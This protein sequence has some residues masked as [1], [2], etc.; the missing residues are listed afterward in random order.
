MVREDHERVSLPKSLQAAANSQSI[1]LIDVDDFLARLW[2]IHLDVKAEGYVHEY[3][4]GMFRSDYMLDTSS[5]PTSLKQVEFNSIS[6]SF[7]GLASLVT[8]LHTELLSFPTP[9]QPLAYPAHPL[10]SSIDANE[11]SS[12]KSAGSPPTN[13]AVPTLIASLAAAHA[14]YGSSKHSPPLPLCVLF[15]V[16]D[17]ERN[18]FDQLALSSHLF[19]HHKIPS[20]RIPTSAIISQTTIPSTQ[21]IRA[22]DRI[23]GYNLRIIVID[24]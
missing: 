8:K 21:K 4:L 12:L 13:E 3:S 7:G 14:A 11:P 22:L 23:L 17:S 19:N 9:Q 20:F 24:D 1:R 5:S 10:F 15:L 16:Q 6:S 18:I 2:K